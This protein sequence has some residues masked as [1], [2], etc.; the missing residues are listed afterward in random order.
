MTLPPMP[1]A[2]RT[3]ASR[4]DQMA[5]LAGAAHEKATDPSIKTLARQ[6]LLELS[7][8]VAGETAR[9]LELTLRDFEKLERVPPELEERR[10]ALSSSAYAAWTRARADD[11]FESFEP[12][13]RACF[14]TAAELARARRGPDD[15]GTSL[16]SAMLDEYET[17]VSPRGSR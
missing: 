3:S 11:D 13:L 17:G 12:I 4:G 2:S 14:E 15:T 5:A 8:S 6:S 10:A 1:Q 9:I 7:D 16:Y